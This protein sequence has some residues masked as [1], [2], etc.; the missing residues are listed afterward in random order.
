M[1]SQAPFSQG[2]AT[3]W[4]EAIC[5]KTIRLTLFS[6]RVD[7][8]E[9]HVFVSLRRQGATLSK[10]R[11]AS[12]GHSESRHKVQKDGMG[13]IRLLEQGVQQLFPPSWAWTEGSN[14]CTRAWATHLPLVP[15][16][17]TRGW[18][19]GAIWCVGLHGAEPSGN[20]TVPDQGWRM[21]EKIISD[22]RRKETHSLRH[23]RIGTSVKF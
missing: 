21:K 13:R 4:K 3:T 15:V 11:A 22:L 8:K 10:L 23:G 17:T 12:Q 20:P 9:G 7:L 2:N 16:R 18:C 14:P 5:S 19:I 1:F 6:G